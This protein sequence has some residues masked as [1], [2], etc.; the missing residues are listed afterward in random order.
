MRICG[1]LGV[2]GNDFGID[3]PSSTKDSGICMDAAVDRAISI[4]SAIGTAEIAA[5]VNKEVA[6][7]G[8]LSRACFATTDGDKRVGVT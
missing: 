7:I 6:I 5:S 3:A 4:V 1:A 2:S 8:P